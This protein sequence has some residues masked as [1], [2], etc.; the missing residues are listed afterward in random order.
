MATATETPSVAARFLAQPK[1][2]LIDGEWVLA[3]HGRTL[4]VYDPAAAARS[5]SPAH[6]RSRGSDRR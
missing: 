6:L 2:M 5:A 4:E 1:R 3:R